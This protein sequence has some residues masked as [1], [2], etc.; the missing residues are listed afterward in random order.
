MRLI[1]A[2][3]LIGL[4]LVSPEFLKSQ[5]I[6]SAGGKVHLSAPKFEDNTEALFQVGSTHLVFRYPSDLKPEDPT[7][8][9]QRSYRIV[10]ALHPAKDAEHAVTDPCSPTIF[11]AGLTESEP[12]VASGKKKDSFEAS[13]PTGGITLVDV[14]WKC[15]KGKSDSDATSNL[16]ARLGEA[17]GLASVIPG[18]K[19]VEYKLDGHVT[20]LDVA[21]GFSKDKSGKRN[22]SAGT[23]LIGGVSMVYEGHLFL[24]T[25]IANDVTLFNRM[26]KSRVQFDGQPSWPLVPFSLGSK[27]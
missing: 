17:D 25:F 24:W 22:A 12:Q 14:D 27:Q 18:S 13:P 21:Q 20:A 2:I 5:E 8:L 11:A 6:N 7:T 3:F 23:T 15:L 9:S 4:S 19:T 16:V 26:L 1:G 10:F